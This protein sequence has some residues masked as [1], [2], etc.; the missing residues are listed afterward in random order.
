ML[1]FVG[2]GAAVNEG[3]KLSDVT[4]RNVQGAGF[5]YLIARQLGLTAGLDVAV[6]PEE[7]TTYI[8]FG[9]AW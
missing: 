8:Q 1:G 3:Q 9:G 2:T 4:L 5:R 7:T 6:G